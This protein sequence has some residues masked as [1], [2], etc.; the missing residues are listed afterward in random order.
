[1]DGWPLWWLNS[2]SSPFFEEYLLVGSKKVGVYYYTKKKK[3]EEDWK[4]YWRRHLS[5]ETRP[6]T[7]FG[8]LPIHR[9]PSLKGD[10]KYFLPSNILFWWEESIRA[11]L[12]KRREGASHSFTKYNI[13]RSLVID[14]VW[15]SNFQQSVGRRQ[16]WFEGLYYC[17]YVLVYWMKMKSL[18]YRR[19]RIAFFSFFAFPISRDFFEGRILFK[20]TALR[21]T[22]IICR[23]AEPNIIWYL[24]WIEC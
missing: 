22:K 8:G 3:D 21:Y 19:E 11:R 2:P 14:T 10:K 20:V 13:Q 24:Y 6:S 1:M 5:P 4:E 16:Q 9:S 18:E 23:P 7:K 12:E 15:S 17:I